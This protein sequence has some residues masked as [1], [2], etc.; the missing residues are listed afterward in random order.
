MILANSLRVSV[1]A[2]AAATVWGCGMQASSPWYQSPPGLSAE[3]G[4][5]VSMSANQAGGTTPDGDTRVVTVDGQTVGPTDWDKVV[6]LPG[7]HTLGVEYNG[8]AA[9]ATV[10]IRATLR[11]G[12]AY[13]V[14]GQRTGPCDAD[15]WLEDHA[16]DQ[17]PSTKLET[18][19]M[20]KPSQYGSSI[21]AV[22]CN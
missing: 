19:L 20:A 14:K 21:M 15:L 16:V 2:L 11:R 6:L 12:D 8:V 7:P 17:A 1:L 9:T 22:V 18:H 3:S 4:A 10:Q 5:T 13:E